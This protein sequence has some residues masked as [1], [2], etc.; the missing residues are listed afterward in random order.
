VSRRL[1]HYHRRGY[2]ESDPAGGPASVAEQAG[3]ALVLLDA[4]EIDRADLVG[5]SFGANVALELALSAPERV[6]GLV[7]LEP[8][9][10]FALAPDTAQYVSQAAE[11]AYP[12]Y[13]RGDRAGA[14]DA[15]LSGAF[16]PGYRRLLER[17]LPGAFEQAVRDADAPFAVEVP[18]L[19]TWA[20]RPR[21]S[22]GCWGQLD[23]PRPG[24]CARDSSAPQPP[25][26]R[27][28]AGAA[29]PTQAAVPAPSFDELFACT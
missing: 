3:D 5:H 19:Q 2:G 10:P 21:G 7:L 6:R 29:C 1:V 25:T 14:L 13:E 4:L 23:D 27:G 9:L 22:A 17:A 20:A 8:L 12:R 26:V 24:S 16:G 15:R 11:A 18:S 28:R